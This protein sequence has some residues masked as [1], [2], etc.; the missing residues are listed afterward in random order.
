MDSIKSRITQV[1]QQLNGLNASQKMLTVSLIVIMA[2]TLLWWGR[3][4]ARPEMEPV[5]NQ[6]FSDENITRITAQLASKRI[7][8]R[9]SGDKVLIPADR[10]FEV[11]ADLSYAQLL[12][13]DTRSGFDEIA[14]KM[15]P[16]NSSEQNKV[17]WN[18]AKEITLAQVIRNFPKVSS[19]VVIIDPTQTRHIE[20]SV[21]PSATINISM[22][23]GEKPRKELI[24]AAVDVVAGAQSGLSRGRINVIVD[25]VSHRL[26]DQN[27]EQ[28]IAGD[29][30]ELIRGYERYY[31]DKISKHLS[32]INGV[33]VSVSV[34]VNTESRTTQRHEYDPENVIHKEKD[35]LIRSGEITNSSPMVVEPGVAPNVG[36]SIDFN[37]A[38]RGNSTNSEEKKTYELYVGES[39]IAINTPAGDATVTGALVRVPRS[40]FVGL[41]KM[42]NPDAKDPDDVLLQ[43]LIDAHLPTIRNDV[44]IFLG[45]KSDDAV[46]VEPYTDIIP[47]LAGAGPPSTTSMS[48]VVGN[49]TKEIALGALAVVSLFMVL[50]MVKR[51]GPAPIIAPSAKPRI[52][53]HLQTRENLAGEGETMLDGMELD[54]EVFCDNQIFGQV[55]TLVRENPDAAANVV[56]QWLNR[57]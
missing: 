57:R 52:P 36:I 6:A 43:P 13:R 54:E 4:A 42:K 16:F 1:Q 53:P 51:G 41:F 7:P 21:L 37:A 32:W 10:K 8:Y 18:R 9:V 34:K 23:D 22:R 44:K 50:M 46:S 38:G 35:I 24:E 12:P 48:S 26:Q 56:Q 40:Y 14:A 39:T 47:V 49:Y 19:A 5:L 11:L 29:A 45:L 3:Y 15:N 17:M 27:D 25:G 2:I 55:S 20:N 28:V 33:L 31:E 30:F